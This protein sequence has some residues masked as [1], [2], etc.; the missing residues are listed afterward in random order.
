MQ[1]VSL[2]HV[3]I[4]VASVARSAAFYMGLFDTPVLRN[5]ALRAQ[6]T[7]PPIRCSVYSQQI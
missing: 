4:R 3:N 2:D 6:P 1:P 7:L 5:L